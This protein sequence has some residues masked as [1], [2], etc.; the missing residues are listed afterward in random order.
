MQGWGM[1]KEV[2]KQLKDKTVYEDINFKETS[3]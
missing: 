2:N 1:T 3:P